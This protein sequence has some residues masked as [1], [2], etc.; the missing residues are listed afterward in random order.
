M[1]NLQELADEQGRQVLYLAAGDYEY[2]L[3][4]RAT[5]KAPNLIDLGEIRQ[6]TPGESAP[7]FELPEREAIPAPGSMSAAEYAEQLAVPRLNPRDPAE[8]VHVFHLLH[9]RLERLHDLMD[10]WRITTLGQLESLLDSTAARHAIPDE[11]GRDCLRMRCRLTRDWIEAWRIGRGKPV[12]RSVLEEADGITAN[13][14][15]RVSDKAEEVGHDAG[16]LMRALEDGEVH[17]YQAGQREA[18]KEWLQNHGHLPNREPLVSD[19]R[20]QRLLQHFGERGSIEEVQ[21][22]IDWLETTLPNE[23]ET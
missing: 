9:D 16:A 6:R 14:I 10:K 2:R 17:R 23:P 3:W 18:L 8:S 20:R 15:D 7:I 1:Q 19:E 13:T 4:E 12:D 5:G 21:A 22:Q 11:E